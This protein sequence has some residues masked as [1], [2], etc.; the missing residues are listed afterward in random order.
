M[1]ERVLVTGATGFVGRHLCRRLS[2]SGYHVRAALRSANASPEG[3]AE[4]VVV[5]D[6]TLQTDWSTA[7]QDVDHVVHAAA[8]AHLSREALAGPSLFDETNAFGTQGLVAASARAQV[9]RFILLSS[10]KVNGEESDGDAYTPFD[11]P[12]P[13]DAYARSKW[14]AEQFVAQVCAA[15]AMKYVIVRPPLVYGAGVQANFLRLMRWVDRGYPLPF[16]AI[17]NKRSFVSVWNLADLI[18][19]TLRNSVAVNRTWM[20]ADG[21]DL[22][23]AELVRRLAAAMGRHAHVFP[24]PES[25]LRFGGRLIGRRAEISRLCGSLRV[26][27]AQTLSLLGWKPSISVDAGLAKTIEWYCSVR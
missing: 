20:V 26:N 23:T 19:S 9:K 13:Q 22:S 11:I 25:A 15:N 18:E 1:S 4:T 3:A 10:V 12:N 24:V 8:R 5:G 6:I 16:G 14:Q 21:E 27:L 2:A 7:L 17:R